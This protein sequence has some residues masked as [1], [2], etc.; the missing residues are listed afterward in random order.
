MSRMEHHEEDNEQVFTRSARTRRAD[1][2][3]WRR[4]ALEPVVGDCVDFLEDWL[5]AANA[6]RMGQEG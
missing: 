4:A 6:E 1:G 2:V 3:G 5:R